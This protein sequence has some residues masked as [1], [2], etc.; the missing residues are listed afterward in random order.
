VATLTRAIRRGF[1]L[2][3]YILVVVVVLW[4]TMELVIGIARI[5]D[6]GPGMSRLPVLMQPKLV[7]YYLHLVL[8]IF[9]FQSYLK[10]IHFLD[11]GS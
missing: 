8:F 6:R 4:H 11:W 7:A 9:L 3:E 5:Y 1:A 2:Y 10:K